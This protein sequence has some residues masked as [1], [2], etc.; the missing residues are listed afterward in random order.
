MA[1]RDA[2]IRPE[3]DHVEL[4][5]DLGSVLDHLATIR[6][7]RSLQRDPIYRG[8]REEIDRVL[9]GF[10]WDLRDSRPACRPEV[11]AVAWNIERGKR[12]DGV[13]DLL[14]THPDLCDADLVLLNEVDIGMGRT[15]NCNVPRDIAGALGMSYVY[16]NLDL[17]LSAGDA[18][19]RSHA[20]PNTL[21]MHGSALLSRLPIAGFF[22][23]TLPEYFDKFHDG[24]KRLGSK[25]ALVCE[26]EGPAGPI[27]VVVPHLDPFAP[28]RHR[29]RQMQIIVRAI[30]ATGHASVL[31]GGDLNTNTYDLGSRPGLAFNLAH[32]FI[33]LG[34]DGTIRQYM[35]P[36]HIFERPTFEVMQRAG[37]TIDGFNDR[38]V[39]T[40][41]FDV[42]DPEL[43]DWTRRYVPRPVER[44]LQRRLEP[45]GGAVPLRIDW[46]AGRHLA[47]LHATVVD[48]P[49]FDGA[50]L[51]DHN[52]LRVDVEPRA[53]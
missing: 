4:R 37:L 46:F 6:R 7:R 33:R 29:A 47:P 24:E 38:T 39:G 22:A 9:R 10:E 41:Y 49:R 52:P 30:E 42:F 20:D 40:T 8:A 12:L 36:E 3:L 17:M 15:K 19:E 13:I 5:H 14:K 43:A 18:F 34:F 2:W 35:T 28:P 51:S 53:G 27:C 44:Y 50:L 32:K 11:R 21:A 1:P 16:C 26:V 45:W 31:L 48:R 23:V 25:R